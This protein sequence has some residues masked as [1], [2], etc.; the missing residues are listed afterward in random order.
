M[1]RMRKEKKHYT[2]TF[3]ARFNFSH[4]LCPGPY[5]QSK[6]I[7]RLSL[8]GKLTYTKVYCPLQ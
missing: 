1:E 3:F 8:L 4:S 6:D 7:A 2:Q 5:P